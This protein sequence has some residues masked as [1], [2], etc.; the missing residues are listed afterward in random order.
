VKS[1][2]NETYYTTKM[3][4]GERRPVK[5]SFADGK[6]HVN[7][8]TVKKRKR[9][10]LPIAKARKV[11]AKRTKQARNRDSKTTSKNVIRDARWAKEPGKYD[12]RNVDTKGKGK[13]IDKDK[14]MDQRTKDRNSRLKKLTSS[15]RKEKDPEKKKKI[16]KQIQK[17]EKL[18]NK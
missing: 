12:Y 2:T 7:V 4:N 13:S 8:V 3:I 10:I 1:L 17:L 6:K 14:A 15:Y 18:T 5:V 11:Q 9:K 16:K